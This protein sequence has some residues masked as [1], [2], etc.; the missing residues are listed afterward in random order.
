MKL[1]PVI[2]SLREKKRYVAFEVISGRRVPFRSVSKALWLSLL[3]LAGDLGASSAGMDVLEE[4]YDE[5][6][7]RGVVRVSHTAQDLVKASMVLVS[8]VDGERVIMKS[9]G[10]SGILAKAKVFVG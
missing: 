2:P 10:S 8:N 5:S 6:S 3:S 1:K 4:L 7:Q 9:L